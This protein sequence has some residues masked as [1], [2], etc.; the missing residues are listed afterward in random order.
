MRE[1][2]RKTG[3]IRENIHQATAQNDGVPHR[4][5]FHRRS[6]QDAAADRRLQI[7]VICNFK[8]V[9]HR[10]QDLIHVAVLGHQ[11]H[12][13]HL[14]CDVVFG[15]AFPSAFLFKRRIVVPD[16]CLISHRL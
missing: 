14:G 2:G 1:D 7:E 11:A 13:F 4:E 6:H 15:L 5:G 9:N 3:L 12:V 10:F 8:I 16:F